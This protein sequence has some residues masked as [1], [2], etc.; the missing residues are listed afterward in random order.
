MCLGALINLGVPL[1]YLTEQLEQLGLSAEYTL[2]AEP[3]TRNG[4]AGTYVQVQLTAV[5]P[6]LLSHSPD[7]PV[8]HLAEIE[9]IIH[10]A[11]LPQRV[12]DWSLAIFHQL[13][14]AE[15]AVH[16]ISPAQVHF[17]EVGATDA[18][19][20]IV[21]TCLGLDW[22]GIDQI[23]CSALPIGGGT[24]KAAHGWLPVPAPA[25]LQ[26]LQMKQV[27]L[28]SNGIP[29]ELVTPTGAAI[30]TT[31]AQQFGDPPAMTL[32]R[33]G[34]GAGSHALPLPNLLRLWIGQIPD[35]HSPHPDGHR[36]AAPTPAH[37]HPPSP[38]PSPSSPP[39]PLSSPPSPPPAP[40]LETITVLETQIDDL[41]PQAVGY[42]FEQLFAV[43]ALD[44]FSQAVGMKKSRPGFLLTVI[45]RPET[46]KACE[47]VLLAET[48]TL[49]VRRQTQQ[50][51]A[52][53]REWHT[54]ETPYGPVRLKLGYDPQTERLLNI[55]PEYE[56]CAQWARQHQV[57]WQ[58]V[59]Q[60]AIAAGQ[61]DLRS[62]LEAKV[63]SQQVPE[64]QSSGNGA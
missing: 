45:C 48:T 9:Q 28:Y 59:H 64:G 29:K 63:P 14:A 20:D 3:V 51:L 37:T 4:Q 25:V 21:G 27:P 22:L 15:G 16:G 5:N 53:R 1:D 2:T 11:D 40:P 58:D 60:A 56:D 42:V 23:A 7:H 44:V 10:S 38:S 32:Q 12:T 39:S 57:P 26:L 49:G 46:L 55:H 36:H 35:T 19:V 62:A 54:V 43:G 18:I 31:L 52:L 24:V 33:V 47:Q 61:G 17:H 41:S 8:R 6:P 13:A 50:R 34:L 30:V